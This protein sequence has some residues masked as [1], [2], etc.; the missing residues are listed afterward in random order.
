MYDQVLKE[1]Q[2]KSK[3]RANTEVNVKNRL[4]SPKSR[5]DD[6]N[7]IQLPKI[8]ISEKKTQASWRRG[9][10]WMHTNT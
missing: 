3:A 1:Y 4:A 5:N 7:N 2:E 9:V 8:K 10:C 6:L